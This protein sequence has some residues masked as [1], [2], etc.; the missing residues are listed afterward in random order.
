MGQNDIQTNSYS[1]QYLQEKGVEIAQIDGDVGL[2]LGSNAAL[3]ME[4]LEVVNSQNGGPFAI[5]T[6]FGSILGGGGCIESATVNSVWVTS[7]WDKTN[8]K[9][10]TEEKGMSIEDRMRCAQVEAFCTRTEDG[11]FQ[12]DLPVRHSKVCFPDN[13]AVAVK[14]LE[15][16]QK[17]FKNRQNLLRD[18]ASQMNKTIETEYAERVPP[19]DKIMEGKLWYLQH[20]GVYHPRSREVLNALPMAE[21]PIQ[22]K[23]IGLKEGL[24]TLRASPCWYFVAC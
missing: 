20:H 23:N 16:L 1:T 19:N 22:V 11:K 24:S 17:R 15:T 7:E 18:Y 2:L 21:H 8:G 12:I 5:R 6:R 13:R 14:R 4:P 10:A 3:A 9:L